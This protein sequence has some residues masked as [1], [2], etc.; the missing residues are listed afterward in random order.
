MKFKISQ[1]QL[2]LKY[3]VVL[4]VATIAGLY[5]Y[6]LHP[7][8]ANMTNM[9]AP[10][11]MIL[12]LIVTHFANFAF[13]IS[14]PNHFYDNHITVTFLSLL[15]ALF[16]SVLL[17]FSFRFHYSFSFLI[18]F[19]PLVWI[20]V[21]WWDHKRTEELRR[22]R[23][24]VIKLGNWQ[25]ITSSSANVIAVSDPNDLGS[26]EFDVLLFDDKTVLPDNWQIHLPK[27]LAT[28]KAVISIGEFVENAYG[29]VSMEHCTSDQFSISASKQLYLF[30]KRCF[31]IVISLIAIALLSPCILIVTIIIKLESQGSVIYR[32]TRVGHGNYTFTLFKLRTMYEDSE[33]SGPRFAQA[34]DPRVTR[35]GRWLRRA[36]IDEWPQF[37]NVIRGEMSLVGPR[38][39]RPEWVE[40]FRKDIAYYDLRHLVRPGITGWAQ[41]THG[42]TSG[43]EGAKIKLQRDLY[44]VKHLG[45][46]LDAIVILRT[47]SALGGVIGRD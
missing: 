21:F 29:R 33:P 12:I 23:Y 42:Y 32:Q 2:L 6:S 7:Q 47:F 26:I 46:Q 38:P 35:I 31:D 10:I 41:V 25:K 3:V 9:F 36:R 15:T 22:E 4:P 43:T 44:Y 17:L 39:E 45:F 40:E 8:Y 5:T 37:V 19:F 11:P 20:W 30:S 16:L 28:G 1:I 27:L 13:L 14:R 34:N 24:A 18:V